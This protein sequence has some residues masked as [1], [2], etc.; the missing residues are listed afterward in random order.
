M[1]FTALK[2]KGVKSSSKPASQATKKPHEPK[3]DKQ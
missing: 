1:K 2:F 3:N